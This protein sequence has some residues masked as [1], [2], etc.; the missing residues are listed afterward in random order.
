MI[1]IYKN[2]LYFLLAICVTFS[3]EGVLKVNSDY[4]VISNSVFSLFII[5]C[6]FILLMKTEKIL[7]K[8][9]FIFSSILGLLF[10]AFLVIGT[11]IYLGRFDLS[12]K[13]VYINILMFSPMTICCISLLLN[14]LSSADTFAIRGEHLF[15]IKIFETPKKIFIYSWI[16]IFLAWTVVLLAFFPGIFNYDASYQFKLADTGYVN[17]FHPLIHTYFIS[18]LLW[19]GKSLGNFEIG[20]FLN[21]IIQMLFLSFSMAYSCFFMSK[22]KA[23]KV[24]ILISLMLFA[25]LP[26]NPLLALSTTKDI[27][28]SGAFLLLFLKTFEMILFTKQFFEKKYN[29]FVFIVLS[30]LMIAFRRNGIYAYIILIPFLFFAIKKFRY[31][32]LCMMI[33]SVLL[34]Q[35]INGQLIK[36][37]GAVPL[38]YETIVVLGVPILQ[39]VN[40][41]N[42]ESDK[43]SE[44]EKNAVY[45]IMPSEYMS[46]YNKYVIDDISYYIDI[47]KIVENPKKYFDLWI[48]IGLKAPESYINAFLS[49]NLPYWYPDMIYPQI[50]LFLETRTKPFYTEEYKK[51]EMKSFIPI[52][53]KAYTNIGNT[54]A[55][56]RIPVLSMLCSPGFNVW[57]LIL[58]VFFCL[59][60][61]RYK[62]IVPSILLFGL[63]AT[64]LA[65]PGGLMR[66]A[67]G[68]MLCIPI[69]I[70]IMTSKGEF[71]SEK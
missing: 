65:A 31:Q 4:F 27:I 62:I 43:L 17:A 47:K 55:H 22:I 58:Y 48:N 64:L 50:Q 26:I 54:G 1:K 30:I 10:S 37:V 8:R 21:S 52:I 41:I 23:P 71:Y 61:K 29:Y 16:I 36:A 14:Y 15:K 32:I 51:M 68:I 60:N 38:E 20:L 70:V 59:Y 7:N 28:F 2:L 5:L 66:Y 63:L 33:S 45:E 53:N 40:A 56:Q 69:L 44:E 42:F 18:I 11:K 19:I 39:V 67:Y 25:L 6:V 35:V 12:E 34:I 13:W 49:L 57:I 9:L 46:K 24:I 3:L